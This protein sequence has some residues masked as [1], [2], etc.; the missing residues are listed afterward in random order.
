MGGDV[1][2]SA[3]LTHSLNVQPVQNGLCFAL[4][5]VRKR[6]RNRP[7]WSESL[8]MLFCSARVSENKLGVWDA[9]VM[10]TRAAASPGNPRGTQHTASP[11]Q[12]ALGQL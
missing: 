2:K 1:F 11:Q 8:L 4:N 7:S 12:E 10:G 5:G 3:S 6:S 9:P